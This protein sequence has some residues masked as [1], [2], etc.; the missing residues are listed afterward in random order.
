CTKAADI[1]SFGIIM[2]ELISEKLPYCD[3][4]HDHELAVKICMGLRPK[5]SQDIPKLFA[6]L[7]MKCWDAE[8]E[9]RPTSKELYQIFIKWNYEKYFSKTEIYSQIEECEIKKNKS[10]KE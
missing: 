2:N 9:N 8:A 6:D 10:K 3:F 1:Y 5:I 4:L 7:I